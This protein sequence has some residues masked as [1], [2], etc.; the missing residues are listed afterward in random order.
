MIPQLIKNYVDTGAARFVSLEFPLTSIHPLAEKAAEA[1]VCAGKQG[2]YW[3]MHDKL[4]ASQSEWSA[5][6]ATADTEVTFF[7][8]Y[9]QGL[10]LDTTAYNQ[11]LD[12]GEAA[13][14]VQGDMMLGDSLQLQGTPSF[15][16][17]DQPYSFYASTDAESLGQAID[18]VA[19]GGSLAQIPFE[20]VPPEGDF[21]I[22]GNTQTGKGLMAAFL[23]YTS[24]ASANFMLNI[25]PQI[26]TTYIDTG[27]LIYLFHPLVAAEGTPDFQA[28]VA[29]ECAG[30]QGKFLDMQTQLYKDQKTWSAASKPATNF[31]AYAK[32]LNLD[33]TKFQTCLTSDLAIMR[34]KAGAV[35]ARQYQ[36]SAAPSFLFPTGQSL[37]GTATFDQFKAAIDSML[38]Q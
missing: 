15:F 16:I 12:K 6:G 22:L 38:G 31:A 9:A 23:D 34:V 13:Q 29:A 32:T 2:K 21:H 26:K 37:D 7:K 14:Q 35:V 17:N 18:F 8:K 33:A 11:C 28:A 3:E 30:E 10:G 27:K 25:F 5:S 1:A 20:I 36:I 19:G 4:F 24:A